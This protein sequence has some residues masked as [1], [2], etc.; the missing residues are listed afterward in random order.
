MTLQPTPFRGDRD[1]D[2]LHD[3][4]RPERQFAGDTRWSWQKFGAEIEAAAAGLKS[5]GVAPGERVMIVHENG[6]AAA[7]LLFAASRCDAWAVP[8]N[9]RQ[10][11]EGTQS[12]GIIGALSR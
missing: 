4:F 9:A 2:A 6:L 12:I 10:S 5:L 1:V 8:V 7:T 3:F 11:A